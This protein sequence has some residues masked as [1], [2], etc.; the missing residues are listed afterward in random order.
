MCPHTFKKNSKPL[1][2]VIGTKQ[3][4]KSSYTILE[5]PLNERHN[6]HARMEIN[7]SRFKVTFVFGWK[8]S[9]KR[10]SLTSTNG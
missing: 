1:A 6:E 4:R 7:A 2:K 8:S 3:Y 5:G 10:G 9:I